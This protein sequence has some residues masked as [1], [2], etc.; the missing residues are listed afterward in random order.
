[1]VTPPARQPDGEIVGTGSP[2][3]LLSGHALVEI[4]FRRN[5]SEVV[6]ATEEPT[7]VL[8]E[9]TSQALATLQRILD[10]DPRHLE[11]IESLQ[12]AAERGGRLSDLV[13]ALEH[14]ASIIED[15]S[16]Q[17]SLLY[18]AGEVLEG[19]G[20]T[21]RAIDKLVALLERDAK[22]GPA[23]KLLAKL[24]NKDG[25]WSAL[26][27]TYQRELGITTLLFDDGETQILVDGAFSRPGLFDVLSQRVGGEASV[28]REGR[29]RAGA[30]GARR[31]CGCRRGRSR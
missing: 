20:E 16:A 4:R 6:V 17:L 12:R 13:A 1:M 26:L 2:R 3:E 22:Y 24:Y 28:H 30:P 23:I 11:A 7:R 10:I 31:A 15:K 14:E 27:A 5:G 8:H 18:R 29:A 9:L 21:E 25:R 19:L